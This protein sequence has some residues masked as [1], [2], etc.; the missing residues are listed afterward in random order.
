MNRIE[1]FLKQHK[2]MILDGAMATEL[3]NR[4][5]VINDALWSARMLEE[6]PE[7]IEQVH[8]DYFMAGADCAMTA[9]Y[10]ATI[11]GF[12]KKGFSRDRAEELI[13]RSVKLAVQAR[14]RF[15]A[16]EANR[17][18]RAYP[19]IVAAAG[20]YG[21]Y[22]A[23]GSEYRGG[24][25]IGEEEL[26][27][28]HR[29]RAELLTEAGA[30]VLAFETIPCLYE[31]KAVAKLMQSFPDTPY[32][33]SFSCKDGEH[34]CD[35]TPIEECAAFLDGCGENM[36]AV[37]V[38]CTPPQYVASLIR[39]AKGAS[40]KPAAVYPNSGETYDASDKTWHGEGE[41]CGF[42]EASRSWFEAGAVLIGGCCRTTPRDIEGV[43]QWVKE[44]R[45][46]GENG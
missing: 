3:E 40:G 6:A 7:K 27:E 25:E 26:I 36:A 1:Q 45:K 18:G 5:C 2:V 13:R 44:L 28:F 43:Y 31:A 21:A 39:R 20:P 10:Q 24:Y 38:N 33:V 15:W 34:T 8:Y 11:P 16:D 14:E 22:L 35:G 12:M 23:D 17:E 4:G 42:G 37:G 30:D 9:S 41:G 46:G 19:L 32:W 29:R